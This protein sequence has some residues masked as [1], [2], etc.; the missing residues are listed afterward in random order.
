M[1]MKY[2]LKDH[3]VMDVIKYLNVFVEDVQGLSQT[4]QS[5]FPFSLMMIRD[6][7]IME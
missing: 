2:S 1:M 5:S 4:A 3:A 7:L 6:I